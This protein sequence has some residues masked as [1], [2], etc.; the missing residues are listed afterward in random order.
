MPPN[1]LS[2]NGKIETQTYCPK[3]SQRRLKFRIPDWTH[4][5]MPRPQKTQNIRRHLD[6]SVEKKICR[7]DLL[8]LTR[9]RKD[10]RRPALYK[11]TA[12]EIEKM[13]SFDSNWVSHHLRFDRGFLNI[14]YFHPYYLGKIPILTN[15]FQMGWF[16]HQQSYGAE[17]GSINRAMELKMRQPTLT[18]IRESST[19]LRVSLF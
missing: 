12:F 10:G 5:G 2:S 18:W 1:S 3:E 14:V 7:L 4:I 9:L 19:T 17:E 11:P 13:R 15:F 6:D 8:L 16:N